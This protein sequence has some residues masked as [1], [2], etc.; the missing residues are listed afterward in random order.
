MGKIKLSKLQTTPFLLQKTSEDGVSKSYSGSF[1]S[2]TLWRIHKWQRIPYSKRSQ[3]LSESCLPVLF[4][5]KIQ[6]WR[7]RRIWV[8]CWI[9][10][11]EATYFITWGGTT[12][13]S[14]NEVP[15]A[16]CFR[17]DKR[18]LHATEKTC[19]PLQIFLSYSSLWKTSPCHRHD[20]QHSLRLHIWDS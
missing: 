18:T 9:S 7:Y 13:T 15:T 19:L 6:P 8:H 12:D 3:L 16:F 17:W 4:I 11:W 5:R 1:T 10:L 14:F 2:C 20:H